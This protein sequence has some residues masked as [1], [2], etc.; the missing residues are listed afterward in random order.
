VVQR[1][2]SA[3]LHKRRTPLIHSLG[4]RRTRVLRPP[5][6]ERCTVRMVR[7]ALEVPGRPQRPPCTPGIVVCAERCTGSHASGL[8]MTARGQRPTEVV[9]SYS[10]VGMAACMNFKNRNRYLQQQQHTAPSLPSAQWLNHTHTHQVT[11]GKARVGAAQ[12][13]TGPRVVLCHLQSTCRSTC[14]SQ[15]LLAQPSPPRQPPLNRTPSQPPC[16]GIDR[17]KRRVASHRT[18]RC[19]CSTRTQC[20]QAKGSKPQT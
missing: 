14:S 5:H 15:T 9:K 19:R 10:T 13:R 3:R 20:G 18:L 11:R 8:Y 2:A 4:V 1:T 17:S 7:P 12:E 16:M 6:A